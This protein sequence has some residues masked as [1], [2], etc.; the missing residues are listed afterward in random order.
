MKV[1]EKRA[2]RKAKVRLTASLRAKQALLA[3]VEDTTVPELWRPQK[4][5]NWLSLELG[6]RLR[7]W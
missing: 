6:S 1:E 5:K 2:A 3:V 4:R 7:R